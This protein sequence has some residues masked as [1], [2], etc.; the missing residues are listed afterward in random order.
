[1]SGRPDF[2]DLL[3]RLRSNDPGVRSAA[4]AELLSHG[5]LGLNTVEAL[6]ALQ[7]AS[8]PFPARADE[9]DTQADLLWAASR[10][11]RR[12]Y[13]SVIEEA[14]ARYGD[15]ARVEALRLLL[16]IGDPRAATAF[17]DLATRHGKG[18][19]GLGTDALIDDPRQLNVLYPRLLA[20]VAFPQLAAEVG[21]A[22]SALCSDGL[23]DPEVLSPQ[24]A[25]VLEAM[26]ARRKAMH[27]A[28]GERD[29]EYKAARCIVTALLDLLGW[30]PGVD[31][32]A[33]LREALA[34][35]D[36]RV[37]AYAV[38]SL[39]RRGACVAPDEMA[40]VVADLELNEW[41]QARLAE[42][43]GLFSP[44]AQG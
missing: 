8:E 5:R 11:P 13:V 20:L 22:T 31:V 26:R 36:P 6:R 23:L 15:R 14:F 38:V 12:V 21:D 43:H 27:T 19:T 35:P 40:E 24:A 41:M 29:P 18:L 10:T 2:N 17:L 30:V 16:K 1:M 39:K 28:G 44:D 33:A 37:K 3:G 25:G 32:E 7:A 42:T 4:G 9:R 34:D